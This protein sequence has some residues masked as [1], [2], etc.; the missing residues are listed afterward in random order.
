MPRLARMAGLV[1]VAILASAMVVPLALPELVA[2]SDVIVHGQVARL[3]SSRTAD[4]ASI[5]T[6]V[7]L[8]I[9][10]VVLSEAEPAKHDQLTFRVE[11][12]AVEGQEVRT[13][14]DPNFTQG[15]EGIFFLS[16]DP[17]G[18]PLSLVGGAQGY[19]RID[20]GMVSVSGEMKPVDAL[21]SEL[22]DND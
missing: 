17:G 14:V 1:T 5:Y 10:D 11:G 15:D 9:I 21:I 22:R 20:G 6:D 19:L 2:Q 16:T 13:S 18:E 12:G 8:Q 3:E 4:G 7:T